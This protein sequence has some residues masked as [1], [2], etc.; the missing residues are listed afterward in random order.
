MQLNQLLVRFYK[1]FN[2]GYERKAKPN[3]TAMPWEVT[4]AGWFPYVIVDIESDVTAVVGANES[5]LLDA[6]AILLTGSGQEQRDFCRY[7]SLFSVEH[8]LR[9]FPEFGARFQTD[10][11]EQ[12]DDEVGGAPYRYIEM[13]TVD[14]SNL[15]D[16]VTK[17]APKGWATVADVFGS[18]DA[19]S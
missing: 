18:A 6:V 13:Q 8:D 16:F 5:E 4:D 1:S 17:V 14:K 11:Q 10:A 15:C 19:C 7:S 2:Y 3:T 9:R 12:V